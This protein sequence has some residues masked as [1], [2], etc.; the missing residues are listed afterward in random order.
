[1]VL[2]GGAMS[3][4]MQAVVCHGPREYRL[5]EVAR[6]VPG[7][8]E[9]LIR[10]EAV[11]ICASDLKCYH[12]AAKFWGDGQRPAYVETPVI[13]GHEF[14]GEVV[15][16]D[17]AAAARWGIAV[18]D[19]V[20]SEQI[21]PCWTCRYCRTGNYH[22]CAPHDI[23]GFKRRTQGAMAPY[24]IYPAGALV[25]RV[26]PD[27]PAAYAAFAEPLSCALHAVERAGITFGDV[28]VVAGCGPIG[29][30][31]VA[32]AAAKSPATVVALDVSDAKLEIARLCG[33][34]VTLNIAQ[35]DAVA[36]IREMTD[37]YG[38]DVYLE[39]TGHPSAV[40]QGLNLLRKLGTF[41]EYS[42]FKD[43]VTVDWSIISDD[44]ELDVR[45]AHLGPYCWPAAIRMIESGRL[46]LD[47]ICGHQL[48]LAD[49]QEGLDLVADGTRS[50]KVSLIP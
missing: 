13:P 14:A 8:G 48:P 21:V 46:P 12:G 50:I 1:M 18:G 49:F 10:V 42:V 6:P 34:D 44:K 26:S 24:M 2:A 23:Y 29:L 38:A 43:D 32:G 36:D 25:H 37:G 11:G 30:G 17:E 16:L 41:V 27:L 3:N 9:A 22:M 40:P 7:P 45:G 35:T 4:T 31:M 20:V 15:E 5:E 39:G 28:V 33:A 47:R 19:R